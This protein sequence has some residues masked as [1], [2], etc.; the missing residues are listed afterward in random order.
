MLKLAQTT[1]AS[2]KKDK[3]AKGFGHA[4]LIG[5]S[6]SPR[7]YGQVLAPGLSSAFRPSLCA[8]FEVA[9]R[10]LVSPCSTCSFRDCG[11]Y[12]QG[13]QAFWSSHV[14]TRKVHEG[15]AV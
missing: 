9:L 11:M 2:T 14:F 5:V 7:P 4:T 8:G 3:N 6:M 12:G 1:E 15:L 13:F 10:F